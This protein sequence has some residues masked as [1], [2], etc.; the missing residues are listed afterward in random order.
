[1]RFQCSIAN[2][3]VFKK[4]GAR[5]TA[6]D[7]FSRFC[8]VLMRIDNGNVILRPIIIFAVTPFRGSANQQHGAV[9]RMPIK[10]NRIKEK[11]QR[12]FNFVLF[13]VCSKLELIAQ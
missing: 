1:M 12:I 2:I 3:N 7:N 6:V 5:F 10:L 8:Q 4:N 11:H 13:R 9:G